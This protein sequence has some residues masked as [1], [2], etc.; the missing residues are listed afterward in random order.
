MKEFYTTVFTGVGIKRQCSWK[1]KAIALFRN[2][3][4][5]ENEFITHQ[6]WSNATKKIKKYKITTLDQ[7]QKK[8][9]SLPIDKTNACR[10]CGT[11]L[12]DKRQKYCKPCKF[13]VIREQRW[14]KR[15]AYL[16]SIGIM[17]LCSN[18]STPIRIK[19]SR[20]KYCK[21]CSE[22]IQKEQNKENGKKYRKEAKKRRMRI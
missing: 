9:T 14:E 13:E 17:K 12:K 1:P 5:Q 19:H 10:N 8:T 21:P 18:C 15:V 11:P 22:K 6:A 16:I 7:Y 20:H 3:R 2:L 4:N